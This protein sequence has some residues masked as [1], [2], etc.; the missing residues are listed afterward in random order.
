M[1]CELVEI[2]KISK[3]TV[4]EQLVKLDYAKRYD[5]WVSHN[6]T[7]ENLME[8]CCCINIPFLKQLVTGNEKWIVYNNVERKS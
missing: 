3:T 8:H 7:E 6:L 2:L 5:V 4:H 1:T